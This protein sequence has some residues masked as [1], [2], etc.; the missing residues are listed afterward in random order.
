MSSTATSIVRTARWGSKRRIDVLGWSQSVGSNKAGCV[1]VICS[2]A[3][4]M[5]TSELHEH[6][7]EPFRPKDSVTGELHRAVPG[8]AHPPWSKREV[9]AEVEVWYAVLHVPA[10]SSHQ[11]WICEP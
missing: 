10:P 5:S 6:L 3:S 8:P 4:F 2:A 1:E 9:A 7:C 11:G